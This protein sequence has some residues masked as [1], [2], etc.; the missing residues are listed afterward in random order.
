MKELM[1]ARMIV[2]ES[3]HLREAGEE[4]AEVRRP[5]VLAIPAKVISVIF[6]PIFVPVYVVYFLINV[7][8]NLFASFTEWGRTKVLIMS[9][10]MY[11]FFP[12]VTVL[13]LKALGFIESVFLRTRKDR[14]IP[15]IACIIWYFWIWHVWRN[16][17]E[18]GYPR[19]MVVFAMAAFFT[20]SAG[21]MANIYMKISMHALAM[22]TALA[23][24]VFLA[25]NQGIPYGIYL[26]CAIFLTGL[27]C[28]ARM[29]VSD[30]SQREIYTGLLIGI[31]SI[32]IANFFT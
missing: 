11:A 28:T 16:I 22:G 10:L 25:A 17:P 21:F 23:F 31:L 14:I 3:N 2:D 19:E 27:V 6:H 13:L 8:Y 24:M 12:I 29:L 32:P 4:V 9:L 20:A 7:H 1:S 30:H 5:A 15:F 18:P 26:A